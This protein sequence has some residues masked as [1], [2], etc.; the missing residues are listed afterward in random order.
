MVTGGLIKLPVAVYALVEDAFARISYLADEVE[1]S[2]RMLDRA[3]QRILA[4][5]FSGQ[6]VEQDTDDESADKL[7]DRIR[8]MRT[9]P[10]VDAPKRPK[11]KTVKA[12]PKQE[13]LT[14]SADWPEKGLAFEA[15]AQRVVLPYG[16]VR[17]ALFELLS[18]T[19]P[20]LI[21]VFDEDEG[22]MLLRRAAR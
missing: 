21:Q 1:R 17:D 18:G 19:S 9:N 15:I 7:L 16:D 6:L 5:A 4:G 2:L 11:A 10:V 8:E 14:D 3:E 12:D 20:K 13:L 22:R